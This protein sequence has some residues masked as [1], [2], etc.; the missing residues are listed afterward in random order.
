MKY[1][2]SIIAVGLLSWTFIP[3]GSI[4][5]AATPTPTPTP[6]V[7]PTPSPTPTPEKKPVTSRL[8]MNVVLWGVDD[9]GDY[10]ALE[11]TTT[12]ILWM[13]AK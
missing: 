13:L 5:F 4:A 10:H 1:I 2:L 12:G 8:L 3:D 6:T 9:N 11:C 7:T